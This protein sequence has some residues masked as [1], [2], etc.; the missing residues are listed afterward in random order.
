MSVLKKLEDKIFKDVLERVKN[1]EQNLFGDLFK[2]LD[3]IE[4]N[5]VAIGE[6]EDKIMS[7]IDDLKQEVSDE[8]VQVTTLVA[9]AAKIDADVAA[10]IAKVA[11]GATPAD[12]TAQLTTIK[13]HTAAL[14]SVNA[15]MVADDLSANP[16]APS[17]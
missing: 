6:K 1:M 10:L 12:I 15:N 11:A 13:A 14:A 2:R 8:D 7:Q 5:L 16:T 4:A 17:A 3:A 9:S